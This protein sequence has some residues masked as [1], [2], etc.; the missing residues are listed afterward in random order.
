MEGGK[1]GA[2][3]GL[4]PAMASACPEW[5]RGH[6]HEETSM[7]VALSTFREGSPINRS[8]MGKAFVPRKIH[9]FRGGDDLCVEI[10]GK[11]MRR[12]VYYC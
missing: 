5:D 9:R 6:N 7:V 2:V 12:N 3:S 8:H 10:K 11:K 1:G 4:S